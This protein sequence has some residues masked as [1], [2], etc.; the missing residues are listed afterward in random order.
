MKNKTCL[1]KKKKKNTNELACSG[2]SSIPLWGLMKGS[3]KWPLLKLVSFIPRP[4][5]RPTDVL[6]SLWCCCGP[7]WGFRHIRNEQGVVGVRGCLWN[8]LVP[9]GVLIFLHSLFSWFPLH[10]VE[11]LWENGEEGFNFWV[12]MFTVLEMNSRASSMKKN[13]DSITEHAS[14]L[15]DF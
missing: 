7:S 4:W 13:K 8:A 6:D 1:Q 11:N 12:L 15:R 14:S 9:R 3:E 2:F 10:K 5:A